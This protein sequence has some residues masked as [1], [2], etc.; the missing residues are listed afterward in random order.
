MA[1]PTTMEEY[2]SLS[3]ALCDV[4][5]LMEPLENVRDRNHKLVSIDPNIY[6]KAFE[7]NSGALEIARLPKICPRTK[8]QNVV[9]HHF[10]EYV[11]LGL[12]IIYPVSTDDQLAE[13]FT[14]PLNQNI[15]VRHR[16]KLCG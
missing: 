11:R 12:I 15:F 4:I 3:T 6:C 5:P 14:K 16:I 13:N 9:Y 1:T 7:D 10:Q 2:L 8:S